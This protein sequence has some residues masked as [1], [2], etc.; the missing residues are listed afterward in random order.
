MRV[1][2][3]LGRLESEVKK[4]VLRCLG[5]LSQVRFCPNFLKLPTRLVPML[6]PTLQLR[7]NL[8]QNSP[9]FR[10]PDYQGDEWKK[11]RASR[12]S[13]SRRFTGI[14]S[15]GN[16]A[17]PV[18]VVLVRRSQE[19]FALDSFGKIGYCSQSVIF[20]NFFSFERVF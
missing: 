3:Y 11:N 5:G 12:I 10:S 6:P 18:G 1:S 17:V 20:P 2:G 16:T 14:P 9:F 15:G 19:F 7:K 4:M 8:D 13:K